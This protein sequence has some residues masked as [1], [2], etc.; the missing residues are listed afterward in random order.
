M[1]FPSAAKKIA[2]AAK[3]KWLN[4]IKAKIRF[5]TILSMKLMSKLRKRQQPPLEPTY[6]VLADDVGD[7]GCQ[8]DQKHHAGIAVVVLHRPD[9][10][11]GVLPHS[12]EH[13]G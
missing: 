12:K 2:L 8:G 1:W 4:G 6:F 10:H 5:F 7:D 3:T 13:G 9:D 11:A